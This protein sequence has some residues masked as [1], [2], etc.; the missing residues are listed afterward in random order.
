VVGVREGS[1]ITQPQTERIK[2]VDEIIDDELQERM[3]TTP[4]HILISAN[5]GL[6]GVRN[7]KIAVALKNMKVG[8]SIIYTEKEFVSIFGKNGRA[9][10][11]SS[12]KRMGVNKPSVSFN[13]NKVYVFNRGEV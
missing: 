3:G 6:A 8:T 2:M 12:L 7:A 5:R 13:N 4:Q 10:L 1:S 11:T 9:S